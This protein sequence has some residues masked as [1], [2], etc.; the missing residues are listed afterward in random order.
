ML[1]LCHKFAALTSSVRTLSSRLVICRPCVQIV[2]QKRD[3]HKPGLSDE[4]LLC[5]GDDKAII[6]WRTNSFCSTVC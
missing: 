1:E 6:E 5:C 4:V 2:P 3:V